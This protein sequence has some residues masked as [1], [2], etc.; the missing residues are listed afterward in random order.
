MRT[1]NSFSILVCYKNLLS[2]YI[3]IPGRDYWLSTSS[4]YSWWPL[5][6]VWLW[7][8][9]PICLTFNQQLH[10]YISTYL[11]TQNAFTKIIRPLIT[12]YTRALMRFRCNGLIQTN[13]EFATLLHSIQKHIHKLQQSS[14]M[15][16]LKI[17]F[18]RILSGFYPDFIQILSRFYPDFIQ[19]FQKLNLFKFQDKIKIKSGRALCLS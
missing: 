4:K 6:A 18:I 17:I 1:Y 5:E 10:T 2:M 16:N 3:Y 7:P 13:L 19:I 8:P 14:K 15:A 9:F 12:H 11:Q